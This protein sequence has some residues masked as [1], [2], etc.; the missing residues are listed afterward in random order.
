[1]SRYS[2]VVHDVLG[3][4]GQDLFDFRLRAPDA[5]GILRMAREHAVDEPGLGPSHGFQFFEDAHG[6]GGVVPGRIHIL[7]AQVIGLGL[8]AAAELHEHG[9]QRHA[10]GLPSGE[11][12]PSSAQKHAGG[13]IQQGGKLCLGSLARHV[14]RGHVG[15]FVGQNARKLVLFV[16][17]LDQPGVDENEAARQGESIRRIVVD[18]LEFE[19]ETGVG[20]PHQVLSH[21]VHILRDDRVVQQFRLARH[22]LGELFSEGDLLLD[23]VEVHTL[24]DVAVSNLAGIVLFTVGG[25]SSGRRKSHGQNHRSPRFHV[26]R[27]ASLS[28]IV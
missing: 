1:M 15:D 22:F 8:I 9:G 4:G 25:K 19:G 11:S 27:P 7:H 24:T 3:P 26:P 6:S 5:V 23:R 12:P 17:D 13:H 21:P 14:P 20:V 16:G 2:E 18:D 28:R 10:H